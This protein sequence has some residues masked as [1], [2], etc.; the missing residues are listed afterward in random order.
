MHSKKIQEVTNWINRQS[1]CNKSSILLL[2]GPSGCGKSAT[3]RVIPDLDVVEWTDEA[4]DGDGG[5]SF[6]DFLLKSSR[7]RTVQ[8]QYGQENRRRKILLIEVIL[9][10]CGMFVGVVCG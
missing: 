10:R 6:A 4:M 5:G 2:T 7:Y 9:F 1:G 3:V 8:D